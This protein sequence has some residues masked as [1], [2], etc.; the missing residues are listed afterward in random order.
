[1]SDSSLIK[2]P[3]Y[4]S[5]NSIWAMILKSVYEITEAIQEK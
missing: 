2:S 3:T 1:M 4:I 5:T